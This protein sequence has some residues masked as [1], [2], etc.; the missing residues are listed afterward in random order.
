[1]KSRDRGSL[2]K[3]PPGSDIF[4]A[5]AKVRADKD[6]TGEEAFELLT[7]YDIPLSTLSQ[8]SAKKLEASFS[9]TTY[10]QIASY[11]WLDPN[12]AGRDMLHL[13]IFR[14]RIP[15]GMFRDIVR[16]VEDALTQYGLIDS[17]DNEE[18]RSRFISSL[19][20]RIVCLFKSI[21]VNKPETLLKSEFTRRGRIEHH[22]IV[23]DSVS[24]VFVEVKKNLDNGKERP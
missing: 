17:H 19:F 6:L 12:G 2:S 18:A 23:L 22:F 8:I 15:T 10:K 5:F 16:D 3:I 1:V 20:N 7:T 13:N 9:N 14:S 24:I 4:E 21:V 11:V